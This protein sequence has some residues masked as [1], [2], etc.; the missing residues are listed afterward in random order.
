MGLL[1]FGNGDGGGGPLAKML[2]NVS[3]VRSV[4]IPDFPGA[5]YRTDRSDA[6]HFTCYYPIFPYSLVYSY[7]LEP[8]P[9]LGT[10]D[11]RPCF[12]NSSAE[13]VRQAII[14]VNYPS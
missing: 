10:D 11:L 6:Q 13:Y 2:E 1:V 5:A 4:R 7:G 8:P 3:L 9:P 12:A 14:R